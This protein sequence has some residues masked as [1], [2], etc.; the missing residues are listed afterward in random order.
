MQ[1][2]DIDSLVK[3]NVD[4]TYQIKNQLLKGKLNDFGLS[5]DMAWEYK[6]KFSSSISSPE[7]D[8]IY[9]EAKNNGAIGGKLLGAGGGGFFLFYVA[10]FKREKVVKKLESM[11]LNIFRFTFDDLGLQTWKIREEQ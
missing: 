3:S 7:L 9:D 10:P 6:R 11:N 4:L 8:R 2:K 1:N 5:L